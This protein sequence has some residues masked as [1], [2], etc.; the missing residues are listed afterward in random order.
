[1]VISTNQPNP[2]ALQQD[3]VLQY[4]VKE[5]QPASS[6]KKALILMHGVGGNEENMYSLNG[7]FPGDLLLIS[8]RGPNALGGGRYAWFEVDFSTGKPV[9]NEQQE[10]ES[11]GLIHQF[12][13]QVKQKYAVEDVYLG[14]FSQ[15]AI[16]SCS[17]GLTAPET[18]KGIIAMSGR[19]LQQIRP[20]VQPTPVLASLN[21][22]VAHGL[23]DSVLP[24]A[25]G[26][27]AKA[28]LESL[29]VKL[30]YN[31]YPIAHQ[32]TAEEMADVVAWMG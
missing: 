25:Y 26:R 14:G 16:M 28:Y 10:A 17:V 5:P 30:S 31:E 29:N 1:M 20:S 11:R 19:I 8:A 24:I 3:L 13:R 6:K 18:V 9:I 32:I 15:G 12:I 7:Y 23:H 4:L 21:I 22:F 27:E 2:V